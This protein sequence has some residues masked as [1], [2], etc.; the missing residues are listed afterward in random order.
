MVLTRSSTGKTKLAPPLN[1]PVDHN[2]LSW[3]QERIIFL[4]VPKTGGTTL[5]SLIENAVGKSAFCPEQFNDLP[6]WPAGLLARYRVFAGHFDR[7]SVNVIPGARK[8]VTLLRDPRARIMSTYRYWRAHSRELAVS[9]NLGYVLAAIDLDFFDFLKWMQQRSIHDVDN[10]YARALGGYLPMTGDPAGRC[11]LEEFG[12][13]E[14]LVE[15]AIKFLQSCTAVGILEEFDCS[16]SLIFQALNLPVPRGQIPTLMKT[17]ELA[18][19]FDRSDSLEDFSINADA[20]R[21]LSKLTRY[22]QEIYRH[23]V[24]LF[25]SRKARLYR[26]NLGGA[27]SLTDSKPEETPTVTRSPIFSQVGE[28]S[29][30]GNKVMLKSV[31]CRSEHF[32]TDWLRFWAERIQPDQN[33]PRL[34]RKLWEFCIIS[35]ALHERGMLKAGRSGVGFA[36]GREPL[37]SLF[38][39]FGTSILATDLKLGS[40]T[41]FEAAGQHA[42]RLDDIFVPRLIPR[43]EFDQRVRFEPADMRDISRFSDASVDFIWSSCAIEHLGTLQAG[44]QFVLSTTR[45]LRPGGVSVHTT[46][47][48]VGSTRNTIECGRSVVYR[49][50]DL[51][52]L[53]A[54]LRFHRCYLEPLDIG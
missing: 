27:A 33:E 38:A 25:S 36:V 29:R 54:N 46:E 50:S 19:R 28:V 5:T 3:D 42:A 53:A 49:S 26:T 34:H 43:R 37:A 10:M 51:E 13:G 4:H 35:Q 44:A 12:G 1:L 31:L 21:E 11:P 47:Y 6:L 52:E 41:V 14:R 20:E 40:G 2:I 7:I 30:L 45:L 16:V 17:D 9:Q 18:I 23:A 48:N 32:N 39:S 22:D 15:E 24:A 8:V